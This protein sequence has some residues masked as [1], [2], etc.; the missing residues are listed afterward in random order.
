MKN[1]FLFIFATLACVP[2]TAAHALTNDITFPVIGDVS[3]TDDFNLDSSRG[4]IHHGNDIL[5]EKMMPLVAAV[6]GTVSYVTW[7][8]ADYG[9][10]VSIHG[11]DGYVYN[12]VHINNDTPGTD[13]DAGG[14]RFAYAPYVFSGARVK[15]GQLIGYMGDSGNA[16]NVHPHLHFEIRDTDDNAFSPYDSLQHAPHITTP[17]TPDQ[18]DDEILPFAEFQ[19]AARIALGNFDDDENLEVAVGA[20]AG[21]GPQVVIYGQGGKLL[22]SFFAFDEATRTG[23]DVAAADTNND[24]VDEVI[25]GS[26]PGMTSTVNVM[27]PA[28]LTI[29]SIPVYGDVPNTDGVRVAAEDMDG[30]GIAEIVTVPASGSSTEGRVFRIDGSVWHT[31]TIA[32]QPCTGGFDVAVRAI[33]EDR[34]PRIVTA[35]GEGCAP[36]IRIFKR[37]G[38]FVRSFY[39]E[40]YSFR[41]GLSVSVANILTDTFPTEILVAPASDAA[42]EFKVLSMRGVLKETRTQ[43]EEWWTGGYDVSAAEDLSYVASLDGRRASVREMNSSSSH[44]G[45]YAFGSFSSSVRDAE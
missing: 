5:G 33:D 22:R 1:F 35:A 24:G 41:E 2:L 34:R 4:R 23:I 28:G 26:G 18:E 19:G 13:D 17:V 16:E 12:Y 42:P 25:V 39:A 32:P 21:G 27:S 44:D 38:K 14:G 10:Y 30:D 9:Y 31:F 15:A 20:G 37:S 3:Y 6:S 8:E 40:D 11:D 29:K 43:F 36:E 45:G 7:P